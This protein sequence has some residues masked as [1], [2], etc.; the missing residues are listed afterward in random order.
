MRNNP[1]RK[2]LVAVSALVA[3]TA[4]WFVPSPGKLTL[5]SGDLSAEQ[6][7]FPQVVFSPKSN[8]SVESNTLIVRVQD[9]I[10][11]A[12]IKLYVNHVWM[13]EGPTWQQL[14]SKQWQ[15]EWQLAIPPSTEPKEL[16]AYHSCDVGC[17][18]WWRRMLPIS[19]TPMDLLCKCQ[20]DPMRPI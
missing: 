18:E 16:V 13:Q 17:V 19:S 15:W 11:W 7:L 1:I 6:L 12:H 2:V 10:G 8:S 3:A 4:F 20:A 5:V 9:P 14:A